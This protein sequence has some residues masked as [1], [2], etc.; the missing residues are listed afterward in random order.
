MRTA[1]AGGPAAPAALAEEKTKKAGQSAAFL[2][3]R[4]LMNAPGEDDLS[5]TLL[6]TGLAN[7]WIFP[8]LLYIFLTRFVNKIRVDQ[9]NWDL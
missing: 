5:Y 2:Q 6:K 4:I 7:K 8:Y 3:Y 1:R 9:Q